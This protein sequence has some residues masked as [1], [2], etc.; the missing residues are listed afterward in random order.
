MLKGREM[1]IKNNDNECEEDK[2]S[3]YLND[4][5]KKFISEMCISTLT[6]K[7]GNKRKLTIQS[8]Y[9]LLGQNIFHSGMSAFAHDFGE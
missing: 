5:I 7:A 6:K 8:L 2:Q 3:C 1:M 4:A 9:S